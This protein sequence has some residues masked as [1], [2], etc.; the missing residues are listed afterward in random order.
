[1][2][3]NGKILPVVVSHGNLTLNVSNSGK[4]LPKQT[5]DTDRRRLGKGS[6]NSN[7]LG[8]SEGKKFFNGENSENDEGIAGL[9]NP[10]A[11]KVESTPSSSK[12]LIKLGG[13]A[14]VKDVIDILNYLE[15]PPKDLIT[16]LKALKKAGALQ[17]DL[18]VI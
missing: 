15:I 16:I 14:T 5:G 18:E 8:K 1:M 9:Q 12:R 13:D 11:A 4:P 3:A 2:G 7:K 10:G 17:A 6:P